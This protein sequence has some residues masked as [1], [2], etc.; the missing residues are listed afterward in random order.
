M[1]AAT[2]WLIE[3]AGAEDP[4]KREAAIG[5]KEVA[6]ENIVHFLTEAEPCPPLQQSWRSCLQQELHALAPATATKLRKALGQNALG[7]GGELLN[8]LTEQPSGGLESAVCAC[9]GP[10]FR[11]G[12]SPSPSFSP[13]T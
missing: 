7:P 9:P 8:Q 13:S 2:R 6:F 5:A 10:S 4:K 1:S 12:P 3:A 11:S